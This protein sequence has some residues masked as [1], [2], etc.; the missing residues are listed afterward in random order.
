MKLN[1]ISQITHNHLLLNLFSIQ[2]LINLQRMQKL[3]LIPLIVHLNHKLA[4]FL[5]YII[6]QTLSD[7][8]IVVKIFHLFLSHINFQ[9]Q[10]GILLQHLVT[11]FAL[12]AL[13]YSATKPTVPV[14]V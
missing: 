11:S 9:P 13:P 8:H 4:L 3:Q 1:K 2:L 12:F 14:K 7:L 5:T 10:Y 6:Q